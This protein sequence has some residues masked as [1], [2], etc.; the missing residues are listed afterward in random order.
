MLPRIKKHVCAEFQEKEVIINPRKTSGGNHYQ[1]TRSD[2]T[3]G[4]MG[5]EKETIEMMPV[6]RIAHHLTCGLTNTQDGGCE[7]CK[8]GK[9]GLLKSKTP[10]EGRLKG[11]GWKVPGGKWMEAGEVGRQT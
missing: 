3:R 11:K 4:K 8:K 7:L 5:L 2:G 6:M 1:S 10:Y 9:N